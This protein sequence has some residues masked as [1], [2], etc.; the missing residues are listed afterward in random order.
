MS[1][2]NL[3]SFVADPSMFNPSAP[4]GAIKFPDGCMM[5]GI[6]KV[7]KKKG[8]LNKAFAKVRTFVQ[9]SLASH[10]KSVTLE[11]AE[12]YRFKHFPRFDKCRALQMQNAAFINESVGIIEK[13]LNAHVDDLA[14]SSGGEDDF[15][16]PPASPMPPAFGGAGAADAFNFAP[17]P[18][19]MAMGGGY[20]SPAPPMMAM[21]GGGHYASPAPPMMAMGGGHHASPAPPMMAGG[22]AY[23]APAPPMMAMGGHYAPAPPMMAMGGHYA[24]MTP[25]MMAQMGYFNAPPAPMRQVAQ[26]DLPSFFQGGVTAISLIAAMN[27]AQ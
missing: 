19:M 21:G 16:A 5:D 11:E 27:A 10:G 1:S 23:Y 8:D 14:A 3:D 22:C 15:V 18:P 2:F 6:N 20:A 25:Q 7:A 12:A 9:A 4:Y 24:P 17:A 26:P 13:I